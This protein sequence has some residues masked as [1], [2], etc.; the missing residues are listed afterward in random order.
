MKILALSPH[1]DDVELGAGGFLLNALHKGAELDVVYCFREKL[2]QV[3][4]QEAGPMLNLEL[5]KKTIA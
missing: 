4:Q 5:A 2:T 3:K 1:P